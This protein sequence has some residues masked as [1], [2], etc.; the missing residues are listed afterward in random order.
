MIRERTSIKV[1]AATL[2]ASSPLPA[3]TPP[4]YPI[5]KLNPASTL[6]PILDRG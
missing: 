1:P 5:P 3:R 4:N 6:A 2:E